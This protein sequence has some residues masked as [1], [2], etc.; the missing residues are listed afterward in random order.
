MRVNYILNVR[1]IFCCVHYKECLFVRNGERKLEVDIFHRL[2]IFHIRIWYIFWLQ[3]GWHPV[4][5][6]QYT[7]TQ[8]QYTE[9][10]S[11]TEYTEQNIL[12]NSNT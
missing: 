9:Q 11:E 4:A 10:H 6:V 5:V 3:L 12:N 1:N 8:K 2:W 7:F